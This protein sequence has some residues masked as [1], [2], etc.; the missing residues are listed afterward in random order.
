M[1]ISNINQLIYSYHMISFIFFC[2]IPTFFIVFP[3]QP[4]HSNLTCQAPLFFFIIDRFELPSLY[5]SHWKL[6]FWHG[7]NLIA[8]II[9][10]VIFMP[11]SLK[12]QWYFLYEEKITI[13]FFYTLFSFP[14]FLNNFYCR[15]ENIHN[16]NHWIFYIVIF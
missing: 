13:Q 14:F 16:R 15:S 1:F 3:L 8:E 11:Y 10:K 6:C 5:I 4:S 12:V 2:S 7:C 9:D